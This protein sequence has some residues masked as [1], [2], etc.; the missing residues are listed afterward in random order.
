MVCYVASRRK[1]EKSLHLGRRRGTGGEVCC[2]PWGFLPAFPARRRPHMEHGGGGLVVYGVG[3][4]GLYAVSLHLPPGGAR[5]TRAGRRRMGR[6]DHEMI[7]VFIAATATPYCLLGV[8]GEIG[9]SCWG[10][11]QLWACL[12]ALAVVTRFEKSQG[13]ISAA[14]VVLGWLSVLDH[15][16]RSGRSPRRWT[17]VVARGDGAPVHAGHRCPGEKV[18]EPFTEV[19][20]VPRSLARH[21]RPRQRLRFRS[22][23]LFRLVAT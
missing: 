4:V 22:D 18:A 20:R 19:V 3:L 14:Y 11:F 10:S 17:A 15:F 5:P 2:T 8:P 9:I 1:A 16:P 13:L 21:G 12:G 23:M 7:F 6:A